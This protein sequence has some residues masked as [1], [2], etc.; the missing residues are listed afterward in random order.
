M[1][2]CLI[3]SAAAIALASAT[4]VAQK[5]TIYEGQSLSASGPLVVANWG[6]GSAREVSEEGYVGAS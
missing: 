3:I 4:G 1:R 2:K 6:S 5:A